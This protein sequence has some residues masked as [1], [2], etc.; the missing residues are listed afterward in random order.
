MSNAV[1]EMLKKK[2]AQIASK[3]SDFRPLTFPQ[4]RTEFRILPSWKPLDEAGEQQAFWA[5]YGKHYIK[6]I[7]GGKEEMAAVVACPDK[8]FAK[9]C[10]VCDL[11]DK[12]LADARLQ[13]MEPSKAPAYQSRATQKFLLNV[14]MLTGPT[15]T[16]PVVV[17]VGSQIF[18]QIIDIYEEYLNS[19][20]DILDIETGVNLV[21]NRTG[22]GQ[23]TAYTVQASPKGSSPITIPETLPNID[24][25]IELDFAKGG[26]RKAVVALSE[27]VGVEPPD[28]AEYASSSIAGA[29]THD[30]DAIESDVI[31]GT[32]EEDD[33]IEDAIAEIEEE[34]KATPPP[35]ASA[36]PKAA[37]KP[38]PESVA[39]ETVDLDEEDFDALLSD[40]DDIDEESA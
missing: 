13:G 18:E 37:A 30:S 35:K 4:G 15:P 8:T 28:D 27:I 10:P 36:K 16:T 25:M 21:V 39:E 34:A 26:E 12:G 11:V 38:K 19:D 5:E 20:I 40:L 29:L 1:R 22:S 24:S 6:K 33:D 31:E 23:S 17:T 9:E 32:L 14:L 7:V 2:K 3:S